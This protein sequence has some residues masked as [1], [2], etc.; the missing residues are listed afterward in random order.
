M[1]NS[2]PREEALLE[3]E[4]SPGVGHLLQCLVFLPQEA[5]HLHITMVM[6]PCLSNTPELSES[7]KKHPSDKVRLFAGPGRWD[8]NFE[9]GLPSLEMV[10]AIIW[11]SLSFLLF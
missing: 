11:E 1:G 3:S 9:L 6:H 5:L 10:D 2:S 8:R 7:G 4:M